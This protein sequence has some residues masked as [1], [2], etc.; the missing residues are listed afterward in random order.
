VTAAVIQ[1]FYDTL[2][3]LHQAV[4]PPRRPRLWVAIAAVAG[5]QR[6]EGRRPRSGPEMSGTLGGVVTIAA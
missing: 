2:T 3:W 4:D 5:E 1:L 6:Y